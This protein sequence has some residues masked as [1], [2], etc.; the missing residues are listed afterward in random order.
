MRS[1][2]GEAPVIVPSEKRALTATAD[3]LKRMSPH[4]RGTL[5]LLTGM[6]ASAA[7]QAA[8]TLAASLE[9]EFQKVEL[10]RIVSKYIGE[11]EK[12][13]RELFEGASSSGVILFF[14]EADALF[15]KRSEVKDAH[16]RYANVEASHL[17]SLLESY[18]GII[19]L[20]V[21]SSTPMVR[22]R[23]RR[24][25]IIIKGNKE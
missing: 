20:A 19:M 11:T 3:E 1:F 13:L 14:D 22:A 18:Q 15:G 4:G 7:E 2:Y 6:T 5:V 8:S 10:S 23:N 9:R 16:D 21:K 25:T 12:N 24:R 17:F